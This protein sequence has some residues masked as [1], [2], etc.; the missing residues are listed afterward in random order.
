MDAALSSGQKIVEPIVEQSIE[1]QFPDMKKEQVKELADVCANET[2]NV[3]KK[4]TDKSI[5]SNLCY[6]G[7]Q[8]WI[9]RLYGKSE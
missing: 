7:K 8:S 5:E 6:K 3:I 2:K 4:G 1:K 9:V